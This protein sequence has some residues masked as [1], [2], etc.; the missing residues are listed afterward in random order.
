MFKKEGTNKNAKRDSEIDFSSCMYVCIK[1][2][3]LGGL[4]LDG[5]DRAS[6]KST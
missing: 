2:L 4:R 5:N 1:M 3:V 6:S